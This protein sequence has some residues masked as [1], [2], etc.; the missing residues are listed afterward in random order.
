MSKQ[1]FFYIILGIV[2]LPGIIAIWLGTEIDVF[3]KFFSTS[4]RAIRLRSFDTHPP[5][6]PDIVAVQLW[7][8]YALF[9]ELQ[10]G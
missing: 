7:N 3:E 4:D 6:N 5:E 1:L 10:F 2:A 9:K 8:R